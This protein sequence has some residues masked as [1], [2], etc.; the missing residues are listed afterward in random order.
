MSATFD[1]LF[2]CY[3][4]PSL[5]EIEMEQSQN[6]HE[7]P[8]L[9]RKTVCSVDAILFL[10]PC[11]L[12]FVH[13]HSKAA[14][15]SYRSIC[16]KSQA[17]SVKKQNVLV[18]NLLVTCSSN[19]KQWVELDKVTEPFWV[20]KPVLVPSRHLLLRFQWGKCK[21]QESP[22][23]ILALQNGSAHPQLSFLQLERSRRTTLPSHANPQ[24]SKEIQLSLG[25]SLLQPDSNPEPISGRFSRLVPHHRLLQS[26][27][28][29]ESQ[30]SVQWLVLIP[31]SCLRLREDWVR[32]LS[33]C[34]L[35]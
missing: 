23:S 4:W 6:T 28:Q 26:L 22:L 9:S 32:T 7:T 12:S 24:L 15:V 5:S 27:G 21:R 3:L 34:L 31:F 25:S 14:K 33:C 2:V 17:P 10:W 35:D 19:Y 16:F 11:I 1:K 8:S 20:L 18:P 29:L 13:I 30:R